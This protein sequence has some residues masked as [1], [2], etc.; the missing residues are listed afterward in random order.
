MAH[1][2]PDGEDPGTRIA[3][4]GYSAWS[5]AENIAGHSDAAAAHDALFCSAGHRVNMLRDTYREVGIGVRVGG[6]WGVTMTEVFATRSGNAFLTG[7]AFS[8]QFV[9]DNFFSLGEGLAGVTI[10]ATAQDPR[11]DL[12]DHHRPDRRILTASSRRHVRSDRL[13]R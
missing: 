12:H 1:T 8:D 3:N 2:N 4:A 13:R 10:A 11:H 9:A 7:V 6:D 5:W